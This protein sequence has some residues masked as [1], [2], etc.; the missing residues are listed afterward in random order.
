MVSRELGFF[1]DVKHISIYAPYCDAFI[2][3]QAMAALISDPRISLTERYGVKLFSLNNWDELFSWL[4]TI[5][6]EMTQEHR[7]GLSTAYCYV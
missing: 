5:E 3:D 6:S 4:E 7:E 2:M 1:Q